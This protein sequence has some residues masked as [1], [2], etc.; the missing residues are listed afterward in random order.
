MK[1]DLNMR[2]QDFLNQNSIISIQSLPKSALADPS[3][4][5]P[6]WEL[7]KDNGC[8]TP[9]SNEFLQLLIYVRNINKLAFHT[10]EGAEAC[11]AKSWR[12]KEHNPDRNLNG[13]GVMTVIRANHLEKSAVNYSCVWG[14]KYP[15]IEGEYANKP[16]AAA[17]VSLISHPR[18]PYAPI[19]HLNVR[20]IKVFDQGKVTTWIG[21][22]ADLTPMVP[23]AEDT[24]LFHSAM[25]EVCERTPHI[26]NYDK[27]K[28]WADDYFFIPHRKESRGVGGIF[29]DF[30]KIEQESDMSLLLDVGQY[31]ARAYAEILSRRIDTPFD[32]ALHEK[33]LYWRGRY[34]EFNLVYDRGTKFGL[35]S[36]GNHEAIFCSLPP[37]V[38]W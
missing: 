7:A 22:G 12:A 5:D 20:C 26:A 23:Y 9:F 2:T 3:F 28:K 16:F 38:R 18:N 15:A 30:V 10:A 29:F 35:M 8:E 37:Q 13:G 31:A 25:K 11:T 14:P 1:N 36:G 17:G 33:H 32:N 34:A 24:E 19:M 27:Y 21:G 4:Q 6:I